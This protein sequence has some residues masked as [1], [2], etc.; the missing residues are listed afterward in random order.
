MLKMNSV[1][2]GQTYLLAAKPSATKILEYSDSNFVYFA[3]VTLGF[4]FMRIPSITL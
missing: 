4:C 2:G 1:L 3:F